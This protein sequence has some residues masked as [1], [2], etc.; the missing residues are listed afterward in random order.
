MKTL[1]IA[2][3]LAAPL[4]INADQRPL[5][6]ANIASARHAL[7]E[8]LLDYTTARFRDVRGNGAALCGFVNA[9]NRMGAYTGWSRFVV[10]FTETPAL[11]I[12][13]EGTSNAFVDVLCGEDGLKM[14][15]RDVTDRLAHR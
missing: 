7:D 15:G 14:Q 8:R 4:Q 12:E 3:A 11:H 10:I 5:T 13:G 1:I 6:D 2:A 9:K